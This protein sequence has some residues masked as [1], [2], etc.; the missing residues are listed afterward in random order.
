MEQPV[1]YVMRGLPGS[2]KSTQAR[3]LSKRI[4]A[5]VVN[6]DALRLALLGSYWT[7]VPEDEARV[8]LY[9]RSLVSDNLSKGLSVIVDATHVSFASGEAQKLVAPQ[10]TE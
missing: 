9:E 2:G 4:G 10:H 1:I 5:E 7:G 6:R 8:S 3:E